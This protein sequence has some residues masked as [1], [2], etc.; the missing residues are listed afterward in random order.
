MVLLSPK[1]ALDST[2]IQ[3]MFSMLIL[4]ILNVNIKNWVSFSVKD[5]SK[6]LMACISLWILLVLQLLDNY[7]M[8]HSR[9]ILSSKDPWIKITKTK[10][11]LIKIEKTWP[12]IRGVGLLRWN[13]KCMKKKILQLDHVRIVWIRT[14]QLHMIKWLQVWN[15]S[16]WIYK[17]N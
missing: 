15:N 1:G 2:I 7:S 8:K 3:T 5:N 11:K 4:P 9:D 14:L 13:N 17:K 10:S 16:T 6:L 12:E